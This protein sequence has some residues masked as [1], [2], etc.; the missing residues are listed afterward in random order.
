MPLFIRERWEIKQ[1]CYRM[2][3][4]SEM[5]PTEDTALYCKAFGN[6][7]CDWRKRAIEEMRADLPSSYRMP[8]SRAFEKREQQDSYSNEAEAYQAALMAKE[9]ATCKQWLKGQ[10]RR[11]AFMNE[12][13]KPCFHPHPIGNHTDEMTATAAIECTSSAT[14][15]HPR[16]CRFHL[17]PYNG[18]REIS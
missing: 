9:R 14:R 11:L 17:C 8:H 1:C 16:K 7:S 13:A 18:H 15:E 6:D 4:T 10:C 3:K 12:D 2:C 5:I